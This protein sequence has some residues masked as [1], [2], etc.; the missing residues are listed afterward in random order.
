MFLKI[1]KDLIITIIILVVSLYGS[2]YIVKNFSK[3]LKFL[4]DNFEKISKN[5]TDKV[6]QKEKTDTSEI[7]EIK[8]QTFPNAEKEA[9]ALFSCLNKY[10]IIDNNKNIIFNEL[11]HLLNLMNVSSTDVDKIASVGITMSAG[12]TSSEKFNRIDNNENKFISTSEMKTMFL[13]S[14]VEKVMLETC[15]TKF[16]DVFTNIDELVSKV[17]EYGDKNN[18]QQISYDEFKTIYMIQLLRFYKRLEPSFNF[19]VIN[20]LF[21]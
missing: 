14:D 9:L 2:K 19:H 12:E 5:V 4:K 15:G 21:Q 20:K 16:S 1:L 17:F 13:S 18:D 3:I 8:N 6:S 10:Q 11:R 7:N